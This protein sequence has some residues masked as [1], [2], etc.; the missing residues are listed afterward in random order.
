MNASEVEIQMTTRN[1]KG[2]CG[3]THRKLGGFKWKG[4]L[5]HCIRVLVFAVVVGVLNLRGD[6][7]GVVFRDFQ[8][9]LSSEFLNKLFYRFYMKI[10][11]NYFVTHKPWGVG[12]DTEYFVLE[13]LNFLMMSLC[14][15]APDMGRVRKDWPKVKNL[16][17]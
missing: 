14:S 16:F 6:K 12:H 17:V 9:E 4:P 13:R 5:S 1:K 10:I 3:T 7:I 2:E 15:D 11:M 8:E